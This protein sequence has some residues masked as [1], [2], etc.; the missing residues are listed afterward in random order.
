[1][2][3]PQWTLVEADHHHLGLLRRFVQRDRYPAVGLHRG[4]RQRRVGDA[5]AGRRPALP[6]G[7]RGQH[8]ADRH[9]A[10]CSARSAAATTGYGTTANT[11]QGNAQGGDHVPDIVGNLRLDQAWGSLHFGAAAHEV[12]GTYYTSTDSSTGQPES[13]WGFAVIGA[14]ELKNL[15]TGVGD[16]LKVEATVRQRRCQVRVRRHLR[17]GR[18]Q[19]VSPRSAMA[20]P[21]RSATCS[22]AST[23]PTAPRSARAMRGTSVR[24]TSTT[25]TRRGAPRCSVRTATSRT[26]VGGDALLLAAANGGRLEHRRTANATGTL[27]PRSFVQVGTRTA[28]DVVKNLTLR[29]RVRSTPGSTRT[30]SGTFTSNT[31]FSGSPSGSVYQLKDQNIFSGHVQATRSF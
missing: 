4:V 14:F 21:W 25:G 8:L 3:D 1:M 9:P 7:W 22:T 28:W 13:T 24:S 5:L 6:F 17:F 18:R 30:S 11:F 2:F 31:N 26:A 29:G 27:R 23:A 20:E 12:H 19:V 10:R 15:P 16:S